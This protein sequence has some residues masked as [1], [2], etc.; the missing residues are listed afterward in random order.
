MSISRKLIGAGAKEDPYV[1]DVF[2]TYLYVGDQSSSSRDIV[3]GIALGDFGVGTSTEFD[4][5]LQLLDKPGGLTGATASKQFTF[6]GW[7]KPDQA[8]GVSVIDLRTSGTTSSFAIGVGTNIGLEGRNSSGTRVLDSYTGNNNPIPYGVWSHLLVSVDLATDSVDVYVNDT[9][10]SGTLTKQNINDTITF[11]PN[12]SPSVLHKIGASTSAPNN[13]P[14]GDRFSGNMAHMYL[15]FTYRPLS[16]EANRRLFIDGNGGSAP[17]APLIALA[18]ILYLPMTQDYAVG[19]NVGTGGDYTP[20]D[21]PTITDL[22]TEYVEGTGEGGMV[23]IKERSQNRPHYLYDT[24]RGAGT[25]LET[26]RNQPESIFSNGNLQSFNSDGFTLGDFYGISETGEDFTSWTFRKARSFFDVVTYVGDGSYEGHTIPH[27]LG[28]EV[29]MII[30]K[31]LNAAEDWVVYHRGSPNPNTK[32][33]RLNS[34]GAESSGARF[35]V[36]PT[37]SNFT[38]A[39]GGEINFAGYEYVAYVFAHDDD[40]DEGM[41]QCGSYTGNGN[42]NGPEIDLGWEPQ[43]LMI[44]SA[45]TAQNWILVDTMRGTDGTMLKANEP[46]V[47]NNQ[48]GVIHVGANGFQLLNNNH[49]V[50]QGGEEYIYMA[51]RRPNKPAEEFEPDELFALTQRTAGPEKYP[52]ISNFPADMGMSRPINDSTSMRIGSRITNVEYLQTENSSAGATDETWGWWDDMRSCG[53]G[54]T[55]RDE[56]DRRG[57]VWRRAPGFFDVVAY[58]GNN[59]DAREVPHNLGVAPEMMWIKRRNNVA[60]WHVYAEPKGN[61]YVMYLDETGAGSKDATW[62]NTTPSDTTFTVN[63]V[64]GVNGQPSNSY[65]AYLFASV[66]GICDIG[67]YTGNGTTLDIDCGFTNGVRFILIRRTDVSAN[68]TFW[69]TT[70]GISSGDDPFLALNTTGAQTKNLNCLSPLSSGVTVKHPNVNTD[71]GEYIYMA[72]A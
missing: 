10:I 26:N 31:A 6:S 48:S 7:F 11:S 5:A 51:I 25:H 68:W 23:W 34:S 18:P 36:E 56:P 40:S 22:G 14:G 59:T 41:I 2:S 55:L 12:P 33:L 66:P 13:V 67:S 4:G 71:G 52:H 69:D 38:V 64:S 63:K 57:W 54:N 49:N 37:S 19:E 21:S 43:W 3:N 53:L 70:Q 35:P 46:D 72:I 30:I 44:K 50:N 15:D 42:T 61:D 9:N 16:V 32:Y 29:G 8:G 28:A 1:D 24:E 39:G 60:P 45:T 27:N 58:T 20:I 62:N 47:E 17:V 65:I